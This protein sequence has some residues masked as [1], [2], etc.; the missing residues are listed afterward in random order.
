MNRSASIYT[1]MYNV[2]WQKMCVGSFLLLLCCVS[3]IP[4]TPTHTHIHPNQQLHRERERFFLTTSLSPPH[5]NHHPPP[6][7][8]ATQTHTCVTPTDPNS[9]RS[10]TFRFCQPRNVGEFL[11]SHTNPKKNLTEREREREREKERERFVFLLEKS[12]IIHLL[13]QFSVFVCEV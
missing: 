4:T 7:S 13:I 11:S 12:I 9:I 6:P 10:S 3:S 5:T 1:S 2:R 8:R